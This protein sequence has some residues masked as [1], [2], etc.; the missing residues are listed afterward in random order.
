MTSVM[1]F[2]GTGVHANTYGLIA[3]LWLDA[4]LHL[5]VNVQQTMLHKLFV[6]YISFT[7]TKL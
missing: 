3:L 1:L 7:A 4:I 6:Y 5:P 2:H